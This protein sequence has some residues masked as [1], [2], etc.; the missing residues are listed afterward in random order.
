M[1]ITP[2]HFGPGAA[3]KGLLGRYMSFTVFAFANVLIDVEPVA[4]FFL[5]G[6][7]AHP[8][9]HTLPGATL[10]MV[11]GVWPGRRICE[12]AIR[13]WN[14]WLRPAQARWLAVE[15]RIGLGAAASGAALGAYSHILIDS[16]MHVDV[17]PLAP[18]VAVN[19]WQGLV[20]IEV[21][22]AACVAA[23]L[24]GIVLMALVRF[25]RARNRRSTGPG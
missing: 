4:L 10:I 16:I 23:G 8:Y 25:R 7:P 12:W 18:F 17:R 1:P 2:F 21:L 3:L 9:L 14:A 24:A 19:H 22:Q 11:L 6:D 13:R 20:S 15:P 5:T